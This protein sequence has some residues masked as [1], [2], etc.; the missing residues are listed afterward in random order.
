VIVIQP[1]PGPGEDPGPASFLGEFTIGRYTA[2][3]AA[4]PADYLLDDELVSV[5]HCRIAPSHLGWAVD[6]LGSTNG[7][8]LNAVRVR[9][10]PVLLRKGDVLRVGRTELVVVPDPR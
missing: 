1:R 4:K 7:T 5:L 9:G 8:Y 6:D 3:G 10:A 2:P